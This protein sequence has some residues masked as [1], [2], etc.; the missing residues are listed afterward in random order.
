MRQT[1]Q[2]RQFCA[3]LAGAGLY[4]TGACKEPEATPA[5]GLKLSVACDMFRGEDAGLPFDTSDRSDPRPEPRTK[6]PPGAALELAKS[7]GYQ[8]FE[9]FDWRDEAERSGFAAARQRHG[10]AAVCIT[11]NKGVRAPGCGLTDPSEREGFLSEIEAAADAAKDFDCTMLVV[12]TGFEREDTPRSAQMDSCVAGLREAVPILERAGMTAVVEP[13]NTLVTRP[14]YF[15][16]GARE[17]LDLIRRVDSANV[18]LLFDIYHVQVT[19]GDLIPQLREN[20]DFIGHFQIGDHP[21]RMQ[22]G[23][24]EINYRN[25]F[26]AI[27]ELQQERRYDGYAGLEYHPSVPLPQTMAEVR[28]LAA[29]S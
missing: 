19:D 12:L 27:Y 11:A 5:T 13:V 14:G 26:R 15:L 7:L 2:R 23:T 21:G 22:P 17:G 8:G 29:F 4:G 18:K 20:I 28:K 1:I 25:V 10:L 24:G 6:Y 9:M 3:A 16:P